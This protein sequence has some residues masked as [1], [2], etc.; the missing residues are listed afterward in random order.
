MFLRRSFQA[1]IKCS[2]LKRQNSEDCYRQLS[3][4]RKAGVIG[5]V[6]VSADTSIAICEKNDKTKALIR[7]ALLSNKFLSDLDDMRIEALVSVMYPKKV[8]ADTRLIFEGETGSHLYVSES[9]SFEIYVGKTYHGSFGPGV[10]FGELALLYN[11]KRQ[12]SIDVSTDGKVWVLDR[13]MFRTIMARSNE[14][15][16]Q[17]NLK[18]LRQIEVFSDLPEEALLKICDLVAVEFYP[19]KSYIIREKQL[20]NKFYIIN[21]GNVQITKNRSNGTE[22]ELMVLKK[23][24][25]FGE[26]AL[27]DNDEPRKANAIAMPPG[28]ECYTI[29][30]KTFLEYLGGLDSI[31]NKNWDDCQKKLVEEDKWDNKFRNLSLSNLVVERTIGTGGYGRVELVTILSIPNVSFAR[32]KVRK[33]MITEGMFQKMIYNEK[34]NLKMCNSPFICKLHRTFKDKR[35]L[36]FLLEACLGGDLRTM[37]NRSGRLENLSARFVT[38]CITEA[39]HHLHSLGIIYRDL[40]PENVVFNEYGYAKLTD[41]GS[42]K[43]IGAHKT[44]TFMGTPE[45]LAPEIIQSKLYN[46][47]IDYWALGILV[48]EML[49]NRTPFLDVTDLDMYDN[50]LSG[51]NENHFPPV[52]KTSAKHFITG[53]L[54]NNPVKRLGCLRHGVQDIRSHRWFHSFDWQA[55]QRQKMRSPITITVKHYLDMRN[56]DR[57]PPDS[58]TA[59][60]DPSDWDT[61]F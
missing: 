54:E 48:Y 59:P 25:Y 30:R 27:F 20:G 37:L 60:V 52:I 57:F 1:H 19:S 14:E 36:Y 18:L 26:R 17:Y 50:I 8:K 44:K 22:Q 46:Q 23:G 43:M 35:Y 10:A 24:D 13:H 58:K 29:E 3:H 55:L 34:N 61:N 33:H 56:F 7:N 51:I 15:S 49:L 12:C 6:D 53:L 38:A 4:Q 31:R 41:F 42:S 40:K 2:G 28:V 32:K 11:T 39:L 45:Y 21:A 9:G 47:A 5:D 16:V